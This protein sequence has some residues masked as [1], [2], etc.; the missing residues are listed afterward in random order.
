[1][2]MPW[3]YF[4]KMDLKLRIYSYNAK[5]DIASAAVGCKNAILTSH[6]HFD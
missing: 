3:N 6:T 4:I 2:I 1:M 5:K